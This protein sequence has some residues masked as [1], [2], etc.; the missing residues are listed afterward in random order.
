VFQQGTDVTD[1]RGKLLIPGLIDMRVFTGEPGTEHRE[2]LQSA[3]RS[4]AAGGVTSI[5]IQ[6]TTDPVMDDASIIDFV[7]RRA[8]NTADVRVYPMAAISKGLKGEQMTEFGL[9]KE[10]G[11]VAVTDATRSL[12]NSRVLSRAMKYARNFRSSG[13]AARRGCR[14][15]RRCHAFRRS[16]HPAW[17]VRHSGGCRTDRA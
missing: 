7:R 8:L 16:S 10:A 6:P 2:T 12:R 11:A 13:G 9:L 3:S 14:P 4:A 15:C 1:A 5:V 17:L